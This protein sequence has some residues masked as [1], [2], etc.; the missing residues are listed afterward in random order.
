MIIDFAVSN[1]RSIKEEVVL[2]AVA[3]KGRKSQGRNGSR[4]LSDDEIAPPLILDGRNIGLLPCLCIFGAN[5]SGKSNV[6][7]ALDHLLGM[8]TSKRNTAR[9]TPEDV[10]PFMLDSESS[11]LPTR[12]QLR[13]ALDRYLSNKSIVTSPSVTL[14]PPQTQLSAHIYTYSLSVKDKKIQEEALHYRP[15]GETKT[16]LL[17]QGQRSEKTGKFAWKNGP[18][19]VHRHIELQSSLPENKSLMSNLYPHYESDVMEPLL[20][21]LDFR[22]LGI[23]LGNEKYDR[24]LATLFIRRFDVLE[25]RVSEIIR[26]FDTGIERIN[27]VQEKAVHANLAE[28]YVV[29][30]SHKIGERRVKWTLDEE[31][32][33][34]QR[35]FVLA[36][37]M[38]YSFES[39]TPMI[40]DEMGSHIHPH[41]THA[42]IRMFQ[43]PRTNPRR[44]Q[45]IFTSHDYTLQGGDLMRRDEIWYTEKRP[46]GTTDLFPL[47]DFLATKNLATDRA[48]MTGRFGAVPILPSEEELAGIPELVA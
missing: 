3:Q 1:Y 43:N 13:V 26:G 24:D 18:D 5:A 46:D 22:W 25:T 6:L 16:R 41:I 29:I 31:S 9:Q 48:Y 21:W 28:S 8:M 15:A 27:I 38:M 11:K 12:F 2:S 10:V 37:R 17:Y 34:T 33:G 4:R 30:V 40:V 35:L 14:L 19:L 23:G 47:T 32:T 20:S 7:M 42:I 44:S 39:G 36:S 45:L